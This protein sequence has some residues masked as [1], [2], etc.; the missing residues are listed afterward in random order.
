[1]FEIMVQKR[2]DTP[3][4]FITGMSGTEVETQSLEM[5]AVG[6]SAEMIR[7]TC[8]CKD[9]W[10]SARSRRESAGSRCRS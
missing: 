8:C 2:I 6:F 3:A 9:S 7:R 4:L 10:Y 5:G 1:V